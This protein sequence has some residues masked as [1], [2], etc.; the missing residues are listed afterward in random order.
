MIPVVLKD[1]RERS[2]KKDELQF[3]FTTRQVLFFKRE[4][5]WAVVGRDPMRGPFKIYSGEE[6]RQYS[7]FNRNHW[8]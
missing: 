4:C 1:G 8:Y 2:V 7:K 5:G 6:R 3:L